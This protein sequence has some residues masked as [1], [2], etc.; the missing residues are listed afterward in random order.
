MVPD[1][2]FDSFGNPIQ[3]QVHSPPVGGCSAWGAEG[4]AFIGLLE[5][6]GP[7]LVDAVGYCSGEVGCLLPVELYGCQAY[8]RAFG[9]K[10]SELVDEALRGRPRRGDAEYQLLLVSSIAVVGFAWVASAGVHGEEEGRL[11]TRA[12]YAAC[13]I[14]HV[15]HFRQAGFMYLATAGEPAEGVLGAAWAPA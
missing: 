8:D 4:H 5:N 9:S 10:V 11:A 2:S 12:L 3:S 7:P 13:S 15:M 14:G 6:P 1:S